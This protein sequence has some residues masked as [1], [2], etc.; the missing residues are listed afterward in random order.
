M[1]HKK[2]LILLFVLSGVGSLQAQESTV[3][4]GGVISAV[5]GESMSYTM[6][7][8]GYHILETSDHNMLEGLQ[9][10]IEIYSHLN[11]YEIDHSGISLYPNPVINTVNLKWDSEAKGSWQYEVYNLLGERIFFNTVYASSIEVDL[12]ALPPST[13]I[14]KVNQNSKNLK[15]IKIVKK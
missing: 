8:V 11:L 14:L 13:Y 7:Q 2:I 5:G 10:P 1:K 3:T 4:T 9:Q 15:N 6:G 12:S